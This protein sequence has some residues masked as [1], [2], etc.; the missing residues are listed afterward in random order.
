MASAVTPRDAYVPLRS[1]RFS[2]IVRSRSGEAFM[3]T[4]C[5]GCQGIFDLQI[6]HLAGYVTDLLPVRW[7]QQ[8]IRLYRH[9][10]TIPRLST[11]CPRFPLRRYSSYCGNLESVFPVIL[12]TPSK[13]WTMAILSTNMKGRYASTLII[14]TPIM[15]KPRTLF[16]LYISLSPI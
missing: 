12:P 13:L 2:Q 9:N 8:A 6:G 7:I 14:Q 1:S 11:A 4:R 16:P 10:T 3:Y 15:D 5:E